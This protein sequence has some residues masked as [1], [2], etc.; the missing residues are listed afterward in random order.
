M[1][2]ITKLILTFEL[3]NKKYSLK[4]IEVGQ[5]G[6]KK[7]KRCLKVK[8]AIIDNFHMKE[9]IQEAKKAGERGEVPVGCILVRSGVK[10][11]ATSNRVEEKKNGLA[12]AELLALELASKK[13]GRYLN[14]F[15]M[16]VSLEPCFMCAGALINARIGRLV[17]AASDVER[18]CCIS[19]YDLTKDRR[20]I[21]HFPIKGGV[22]S[23][24]SSKL[25]RDFFKNRR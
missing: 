1:K 11:L 18:G 21:H 4:A 19:A 16:Y 23:S 2:N 10:I 15:T 5:K 6:K 7:W 14:D 17:F 22:L 20:K 8:R 9:A 24:E 12:H 3:I 13:F 25:L